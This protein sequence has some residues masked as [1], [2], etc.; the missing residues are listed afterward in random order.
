MVVDNDAGN[1]LNLVDH[2]QSGFDTHDHDRC[3]HC[4][5]QFSIGADDG[6]TFDPCYRQTCFGIN[7]M[8]VFFSI[9]YYKLF[10]ITRGG[11][12][13]VGDVEVGEGM[14]FTIRICNADGP[15]FAIGLQSGPRLHLQCR[16]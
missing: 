6:N 15:G 1:L 12:G 4:I 5:C 7:C 16:C 8:G 13:L 2:V 14:V 10:I 3:R 9:D 11:N